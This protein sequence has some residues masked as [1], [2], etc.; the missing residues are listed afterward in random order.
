MMEEFP[1]PKYLFVQMSAALYT[2]MYNK[3]WTNFLVEKR[4]GMFE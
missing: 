2:W 4:V 1:L 3:K